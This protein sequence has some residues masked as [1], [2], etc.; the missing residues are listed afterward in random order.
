MS[1]PASTYRGARRRALLASEGFKLSRAVRR[2][3]RRLQ[4]PLR[5]VPPKRLLMARERRELINALSH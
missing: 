2:R 3:W 4:H 1:R 5:Y